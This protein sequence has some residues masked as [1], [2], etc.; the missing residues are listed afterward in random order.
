MENRG[1]GDALDVT[2]QL[3]SVDGG[4]DLKGLI[5]RDN[6]STVKF[7]QSAD[8]RI[9][10]FDG[11]APEAPIATGMIYGVLKDGARTALDLVE[12][13]RRA[14]VGIYWSEGPRARRRHR[15]FTIDMPEGV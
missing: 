2:I 3:I 11:K 9:E 6:V 13:P 10:R 14:V 8:V 15:K 5:F 4:S 1:L 12:L 7:S